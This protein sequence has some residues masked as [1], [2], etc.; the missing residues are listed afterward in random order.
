M[1]EIN[2]RFS[3][4][5]IFSRIYQSNNYLIAKLLT[6][7]ADILDPEEAKNI[8]NFL[9]GKSIPVDLEKALQEKQYLLDETSE[10]K[11]FNQKYLDFIDSR[12]QEIGRAHV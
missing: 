7:N 5:N 8:Q 11:L 6:G 2:K 4:H 12:D 3:K 9:S 1:P 10:K